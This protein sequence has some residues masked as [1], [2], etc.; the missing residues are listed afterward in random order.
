MVYFGTPHSGSLAADRLLPLANI[1]KVVFGDV[2]NDHV[3]TLRGSKAQAL[4]FNISQSFRHVTTNKVIISVYETKPTAPL[5]MVV[6]V[7]HFT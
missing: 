1:A 7:A 6:R 2:R 5:N 4:L 3:K